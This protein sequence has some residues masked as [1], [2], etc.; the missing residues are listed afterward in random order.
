MP[1]LVICIVG[2]PSG[3]PPTGADMGAMTGFGITGDD[4]DNPP[5][6]KGILG[7]SC[8]FFA[9]LN[10]WVDGDGDGVLVLLP[11]ASPIER[12]RL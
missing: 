7:A 8:I 4:K 10:L 12:D 1:R 11:V 6:D 9:G 5:T 2:N 3:K